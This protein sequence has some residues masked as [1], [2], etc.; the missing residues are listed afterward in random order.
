MVK[1]TLVVAEITFKVAVIAFSV[2]KIT[3][4][5]RI[6]FQVDVITSS[7]VKI[8]FKNGSTEYKSNLVSKTNIYII[9]KVNMSETSCWY[10]LKN[11]LNCSN[12]AIK[13]KLNA[14]LYISYLI[15]IKYYLST[16]KPWIMTFN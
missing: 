1:I 12:G 4:V 7:V 3:F 10:S 11:V 15:K 8:S 9:E 13:Y 5:V 14:L 2:T 16:L 6:T